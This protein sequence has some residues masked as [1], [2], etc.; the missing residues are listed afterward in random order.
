MFEKQQQESELLMQVFNLLE[1]GQGLSQRTMAAELG[2]ALGRANAFLKDFQAQ[3][4][5]QKTTSQAN[6]YQ[7]RLTSRG[8]CEKNRLA[9]GLLQNELTIIEK[10]KKSLYQALQ[11]AENRGFTGVYACGGGPLKELLWLTD[12][13]KNAQMVNGF[14]CPQ[15]KSGTL[16]SLPVHSDLK[17]LDPSC[18]L[19][20]TDSHKPADLLTLLTGHCGTGRVIVPG[21]LRNLIT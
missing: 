5:I 8:K 3:G 9:A 14:F 16:Y 19:I 1:Q 10:S 18:A 6:R 13:A 2:I 4:L 15:A 21:I 11:T 17:E 7:Y 12:Q 20:V